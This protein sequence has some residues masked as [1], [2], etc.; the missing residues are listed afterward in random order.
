MRSAAAE[1]VAG[2]AVGG[3]V[4]ISAALQPNMLGIFGSS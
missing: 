4:I 1:R 3:F 2:G